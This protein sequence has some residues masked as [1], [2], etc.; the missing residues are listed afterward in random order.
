MRISTQLRIEPDLYEKVKDIACREK[1]S[2]NAQME[3][4]IEKSVLD[5]YLNSEDIHGRKTN[6]SEC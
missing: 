2:I 6:R 1:R 3:L 4:F 5:Y